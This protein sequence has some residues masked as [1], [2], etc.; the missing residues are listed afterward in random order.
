MPLSLS[1][2][3]FERIIK[4]KHSCGNLLL[5]DYLDVCYGYHDN[6]RYTELD[7]LQ[8]LFLKLVSIGTKQLVSLS[9]YRTLF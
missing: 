5:H 8:L 4:K 7:L 3:I 9:Q 6:K 2:L 1:L